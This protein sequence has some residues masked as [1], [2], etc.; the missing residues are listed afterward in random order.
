[1][2][3]DAQIKAAETR[4]RELLEREPRAMGARFDRQSSRVELI[5]ANGCAYAFP[6][7]LVEDLQGA[8]D[9]ALARVEVDGLGF[10]LGLPQGLLHDRR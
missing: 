5:L 7:H 10:N 3:A 4:G 9:E 6:A 1:M 2:R 8:A